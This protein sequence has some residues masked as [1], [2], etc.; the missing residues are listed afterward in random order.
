[1]NDEGHAEHICHDADHPDGCPYQPMA[2]GPDARSVFPADAFMPASVEAGPTREERVP[3]S[4][5]Q[6]TQPLTDAELADIERRADI[7]DSIDYVCDESTMSDLR[8]MLAELRRTRAEHDSAL[9]DLLH[10]SHLHWENCPFD[11]EDCY[12]C[13]GYERIRASAEDRKH[14]KAPNQ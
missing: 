13:E 10:Y 3:M 12:L 5:D 9:A 7:T 2:D 1:M 4:D 11:E 8:R 6:P 14:G